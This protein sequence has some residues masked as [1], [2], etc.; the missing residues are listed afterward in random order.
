MGLVQQLRQGTHLSL[1]SAMRPPGR[2]KTM[3]QPTDNAPI[4]TQ[5]QRNAWLVLGGYLAAVDG[6]AAEEE[7]ALIA[8]AAGQDVDIDAVRS[9]VRQGAS[10][11]SLPGDAV[12]I[13]L[14]CPMEIRL[15][16][17]TEIAHA[18]AADG[19]SNAELGRLA[20]IAEA[21]LGEKLRDSFVRLCQLEEEA[22]LLRQR[23]LS[24]A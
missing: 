7:S 21:T 15:I 19:I 14:T 2:M 11:P 17:L 10:A 1:V 24:H 18:C 5:E 22:T 8:S 3:S 4:L 9:H 23:L 6:L 12:S 16:C 13:S 20:E